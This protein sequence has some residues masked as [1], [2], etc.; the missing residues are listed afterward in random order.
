MIPESRDAAAADMKARV[1]KE[2]EIAKLKKRIACLRKLRGK[3]G[4]GEWRITE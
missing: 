4:R 1:T 3:P 2:R